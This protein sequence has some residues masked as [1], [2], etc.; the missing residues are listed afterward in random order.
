VV[1]ECGNR[2]HLTEFDI[3]ITQTPSNFVTKLRKHLKTRRL[4]GIKQIGNDRVLVMQFS[5]GMF[6]LVFEFFSAGNIILLDENYKILALNRMVQEG[7]DND[8]YGV[9]EPYRMFDKSLFEDKVEFCPVLFTVEQVQLWINGHKE[10]VQEKSQISG[11]NRKKNKVYSIHKL[12]FANCSHLPGDLILKNLI[13]VGINGCCSSFDFDG[14][15]EKLEK[16]VKGLELAEKEFVALTADD[17]QVTG[18][19]VSKKNPNFQCNDDGVNPGDDSVNHGDSLEFLLDEFHPF[20][21]YKEHEE[22]YK[23]TPIAGYNKTLDTFFSTIESTKNAIKIEKQK[24]QAANRLDHARN[25]RDKQIQSLVEQQQSNMKKGDTIIYCADLVSSCCSMV[26]TLVNQ[27]MDWTNIESYIKLEQGRGNAIA[28]SIKLPLNLKDNKINLVLPDADAQNEDDFEN[29]SSSMESSCS[30]ESES[31]SESD[32]DSESESDDEEL[33]KSVKK[34]RKKPGKTPGKKPQNKLQNNVTV[35]ID[36]SLSPYANASLYFDT[37]KTAESKQ[38]KVEKSTN[39]ALKNAEKKISRDL[40]QNLKQENDTLKQIRPKFW[41]E[42]FYWFVSSDGYLCLAGR[43]DSQTDMIYFR[44]FNDNDFYVSGDMEGSLKVFIKNPFKGEDIPPSTLTQAGIFAVSASSAWNSKAIVS[45]WVVSGTQ[46]SK[47][48]FDDSL[49]GR[50]AFNIKG[51]KE[52]LPPSQLSM[53][54]GFYLLAD[55][56]TTV[57]YKTGREAREKEHGL[58]IVMDAKK[59]DLEI[60]KIK[61]KEM[62]DSMEKVSVDERAQDCKPAEEETVDD[63]SESKDDSGIVEENKPEV[64][65]VRGKKA[66]LKKIA[67]KYGDQD[68]EEKLLRLD[69]LGTL[70]QIRQAEQKKEE[71]EKREL[72]RQQAKYKQSE[73]SERRKKQDS[74][75]YFKYLTQETNEDESSVTNYLEIL[76]SFISRAQVS[77]QFIAAVPVFAPW[78]SLGKFKYKVKIMPGIGKKGKA[79]ND[80]INYFVNRKMDESS[81]DTDL[82]WPRERELI[83][84][85][86]PNDTM[87]VFTVNKLKLVL[88]GGSSADGSKGGK[89]TSQKK[90]SKKGKK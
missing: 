14:D 75:E 80:G 16:I 31:E 20:K 50:G 60:E 67:S 46:V 61:L 42:K 29:E 56:D 63:S 51:K 33:I 69:A 23:F 22:N 11:G 8:K 4:S 30:S 44:H 85:I 57:K 59:Q 47:K 32:S 49:I 43:D 68:E 89:K 71:E 64:K 39:L 73:A 27:Q 41:F 12:L 2:V 9:N 77:D 15:K 81:T 72:E 36:L 83:E 34:P 84:A 21:P 79:V 48:D 10:K 58:K 53:G 38:I 74:R 66:K 24:Q 52:Y 6:Y 5:D 7:E 86:K 3:P 17:A 45:A 70:K 88:P 82:D 1:V 13:D 18:Y 55:S 87:G 19:V 35:W 76:D 90:G 26:Q 78:S 54:L 25:E 28:K 37:K 62:Q 65:K 40:K